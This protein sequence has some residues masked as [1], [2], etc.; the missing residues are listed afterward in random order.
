MK[1]NIIGIDNLND[2]YDVNLKIQRK[3]KLIEAS[4]NFDTSFNFYQISIENKDALNNIFI[5]EKPLKVVNLAAQAGVRYSLTNPDVYIKRTC[6][7]WKY[8]GVL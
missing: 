4:K 6:W 1:G 8:L 3:S 7:I 2:Y 5:N